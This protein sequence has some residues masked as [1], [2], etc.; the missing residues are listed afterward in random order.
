MSVSAEITPQEAAATQKK[1]TGKVLLTAPAG[2]W[3]TA[4]VFLLSMS[5]L[6]LR[7]YPALLAVLLIMARTFTRDRYAFLIQVTLLIGGYA[8]TDS[9]VT[10]INM[11]RIA[12]PV[13]L[14]LMFLV[15][16]DKVTLRI[17]IAWAIYFGLLFL[18]A[19][20]S[21]ESMRIQIRSIVNYASLIYIFVP[22][23]ILANRRFSYDS[24]VR[25][26][27]PYAFILCVFYILDAFVLSGFVLIPRSHI[28]EGDTMFYDLY[29]SPLSGSVIRKYP[30]GLYI[31][32]LLVL[33]LA[34]EYRLR[35][36]QWC[37]VVVALISTQ[38]FTFISG[39]VFVFFIIQSGLRRILLYGVLGVL[40]GVALYYIDG[41]MEYTEA[42]EFVNHTPMR[43]KSS[44][45]QI[46]DLRNAVDDEDIAEFGSGRIAQAI[47][48]LELL[49]QLE[50]EWRGL[51]FLDR[52][53]TDN[54]KFI[55]E[56]EYYK[57][58]SESIEVATNIE[59]VVLQILVSIGYIG[60]IVHIL[61]YAYTYWAVRKLKHA[62]YYLSVLLIFTW[63]GFGGFEGLIYYMGVQMAALALAVPLLQ[64]RSDLA[65][66][67]PDSNL[68]ESCKPTT[69][70]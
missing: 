30:P 22:L 35:V 55:I 4:L 67:S 70:A 9:T 34:R 33:P 58:Q 39:I 25:A 20:R 54:P 31:L 13:C 60:L 1:S 52:Y 12:F 50:R 69:D 66:G 46:L 38:T 5:A 57:D 48:K 45:D 62:K 37:V 43:I 19:M 61:F 11:S 21:E 3:I 53:E 51:G 10:I 68:T 26:V 42:G 15:R 29:W 2:S 27:W 8:L 23:A 17:T 28:W 59:I 44:V 6:G 18:M 24:F 64:Y 36:W 56:N 65:Y 41:T 7:F 40:G 16:K 63:L 32:A 14:L 47:P 49:Y